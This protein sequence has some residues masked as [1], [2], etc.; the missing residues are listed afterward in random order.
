[1]SNKFKKISTIFDKMGS[2]SAT[3]KESTPEETIMPTK[4]K[5]ATAKEAPAK[6]KPARKPRKTVEL[7]DESDLEILDPFNSGEDE[8]EDED[9]AVPQRPRR[10]RSARAA[11]VP[12]KSY[13]ET[14]ELSDDSFIEDDEEEDQG[15]EEDSDVSFNGE[16]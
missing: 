13:S 5:P 11:S 6:P 10:Q 8:N 3:S 4:T 2:A 9:D 7:S 15:Q 12:K 16:D 1:M 14:I